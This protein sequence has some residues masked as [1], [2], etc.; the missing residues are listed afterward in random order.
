[1]LMLYQYAITFSQDD[2]FSLDTKHEKWEEIRKFTHRVVLADPIEMFKQIDTF[3]KGI[4]TAM[5]L[6]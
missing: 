5:A 2:I 1:M 6:G 4:E 3:R